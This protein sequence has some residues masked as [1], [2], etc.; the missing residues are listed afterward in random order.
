MRRN[1]LDFSINEWYILVKGGDKIHD[2]I[3]FIFSFFVS[4]N[5]FSLILINLKSKK[6][7]S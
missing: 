4:L 2:I 7:F 1:F 6:I 5:I 3:I